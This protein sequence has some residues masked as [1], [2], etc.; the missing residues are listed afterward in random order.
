MMTPGENPGS[1]S[2]YRRPW[3]ALLWVLAGLVGTGAAAALWRGA[4]AVLGPGTAQL[5]YLVLLSAPMIVAAAIAIAVCA[6]PGFM[7]RVVFSGTWM[8]VVLGLSLGLVARALVEVVAPTTGSLLAGFGFISYTAIVVTA[9]GAAFVSPVVEEFF[10]RGLAVAALLDLC[11]TLGRA[12]AGIV[13]VALSTCAFVVM[14][15]FLAGG[16]VTWGQLLAPLFVGVGCGIVF[17]V[18]RR[19][20]SSLLFHIVFNAIGVVLLIW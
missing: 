14:H 5:A 8:D 12:V 18:T 15:V 6:K 3:A 17:V 11:R 7:R 4:S 19:L 13:S 9:V 10:F 1:S 2:F 20:L 16:V